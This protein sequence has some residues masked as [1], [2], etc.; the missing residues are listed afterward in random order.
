MKALE[1][2]ERQAEEAVQREEVTYKWWLRFNYALSTVLSAER[3]ILTDKQQNYIDSFLPHFP[4]NI[5]MPTINELGIIAINR[6][7]PQGILM[8]GLTHTEKIVHNE[9]MSPAEFFLHDMEHASATITQNNRATDISQKAFHDRFSREIENV[10][11]KEREN[12]EL[13]HF[14]LTHELGDHSMTPYRGANLKELLMGVGRIEKDLRAFRQ[15]SSFKETMIMAEDYMRVYSKVK[16]SFKRDPDRIDF[17]QAQLSDE[18]AEEIQ[19]SI[20]E[21]LDKALEQ[22]NP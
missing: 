19:R 20:R 7:G 1:T 10:P 21:S 22:Y 18:E 12:I 14:I 11:N 4:T 2:L 9:R 5:L 17:V 15:F 3:G 6:A 8:A 16:D 13:A